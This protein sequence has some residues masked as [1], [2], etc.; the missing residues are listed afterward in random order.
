MTENTIS[1]ELLEPSLPGAWIAEHPGIWQMDLLSASEM[2][3]FCHDRG[4]SFSSF[5]DDI[6][7]L[8]QLGLL[9]ADLVESRREYK[10]A[11]LIDCGRNSRG[12][13]I[14]SDERRLRK[15]PNGLRKS[16]KTA[17]SLPAGIKLLFHPF[18]YYV[19]YHLDKELELSISR[20]QMFNQEGYP[21]VLD[22]ILSRF[23]N[24]SSSDQ[25]IPRIK[26][27][28]DVASLTIITEPCMYV[29]IFRSIRYSLSEIQNMDT[30][31][32]EIQSK[33]DRYWQDH[34]A[35]LYQRIGIEGLEEIR[36]EL[37]IVTQMLDSNRWVHTMLCL[38][39]GN[40]RTELK[41]RL[42]GALILRTM[43]E[44]LRRATEKAFNTKLREE[45]ELGFG[46]MPD[47]V[48]AKVYGSN[49]LLDGDENVAREFMRQYE[50]HYGLRLRFY[51]EGATEW[52]ALRHQFQ[53]VGANYI[54]VINLAGEVAQKRGKGVS[55]RENLRSDIAMHV[56]SIVLIDGDRPDFVSAVKKAA[57]DDEICGCFF[58]SA[59]DFEFANFDL[60]ELEE[61]LWLIASE[62]EENKVTE[63]DRQRLHEAI[64]NVSNAEE[65][66]K[67][68]GKALPQLAHF[69]KGEKW[70]EKLIE[71]TW[72]HPDR[73]DNERQVIEAI[74]VALT[75]RTASYEITRRE[76]RVDESTGQLVK[77]PPKLLKTD[78]PK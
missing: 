68:A 48:K 37:C 50:L 24:W 55:F 17:K 28:N 72:D 43:A 66:K 1:P 9:K 32:E 73:Q 59:K 49:R 67:Q 41:D 33:I 27:W 64:K 25:F 5:E 71:Y 77:R 20:M 26:A 22:I 38:G 54:E 12:H 8:W 51:V 53:A 63:E 10:R 4:L 14:Y 13:Y 35:D 30:W 6:I 62:D 15:R 47:D 7:Q 19:L 52:A 75:T 36:Q 21:R 39:R 74:R 34:V 60:S 31:R 11:G 16:V 29:R 2:A 70:G 23:N 65:L 58:I 61:V 42:G 18:R 69:T 40:L 57:T 3:R 44:M 46:W 56:F 76:Y 78:V 45:D